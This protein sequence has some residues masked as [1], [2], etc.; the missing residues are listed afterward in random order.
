MSDIRLLRARAV[1]AKVGLSRGHIYKLIAA[2][3]FP[4]PVPLSQSARAWRSDEIDNWIEER[5]A[6]RE[7]PE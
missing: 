5:T 4:K 6:L 7:D 3:Q 1:V 2:G